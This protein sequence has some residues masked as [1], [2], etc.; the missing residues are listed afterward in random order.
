MGVDLT[1]DA[2]IPELSDGV[3]LKVTITDMGDDTGDALLYEDETI[4]LLGNI[5]VPPLTCFLLPI[6]SHVSLC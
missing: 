6:F 2:V 4:R 5:L 3:A 1:C